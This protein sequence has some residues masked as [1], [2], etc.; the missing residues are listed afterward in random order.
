MTGSIARRG[1]LPSLIP[2]AIALVCPIFGLSGSP[3]HSTT[4]SSGTCG[5]TYRPKN[6]PSSTTDGGQLGTR[7]ATQAPSRPA[8]R[9]GHAYVGG[10]RALLNAGSYQPRGRR[11]PHPGNCRPPR[12]SAIDPIPSWED[13]PTLDAGCCAARRPPRHG[14]QRCHPGHCALAATRSGAGFVS[15]YREKGRC[16]PAGSGA[17]GHG[18]ELHW[19]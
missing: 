7:T 6:G 13:H 12:C 16:R 14:P 5:H 1:S 3:H 4:C 19:L 17:L 11:A 18:D 8:H 15:G 2:S 9:S 10:I